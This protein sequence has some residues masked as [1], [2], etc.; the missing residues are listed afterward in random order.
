MEEPLTQFHCPAETMQAMQTW[1][2]NTL[3]A[4]TPIQIHKSIKT[5][6]QHNKTTPPVQ[7]HHAMHPCTDPCT[8]QLV[9]HKNAPIDPTQPIQNRTTR[10]Y[11]CSFTKFHSHKV[12]RLL[13]C[14]NLTRF[15]LRGKI[16][17]SPYSVFTLGTLVFT[18]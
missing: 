14:S 2:Y 5:G 4:I 3:H 18:H 15:L 10:Y 9:F 7:A 6:T 1:V 16:P 11:C 12:T 17:F 8:A 13:G